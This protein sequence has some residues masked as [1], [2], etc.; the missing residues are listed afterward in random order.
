MTM[1][2]DAYLA[3]LMREADPHGQQSVEWLYDRVGFCTASRFKDACDVLK[4]GSESAK[5]RNY[6]LETVAARLIG[7][8][9]EH[10]VSDEMQWGTDQEPHARMAYEAATGAMVD[11]V[12]FLRHPTVEWCGGSPDGLI[13]KDGGIE[14][15]C[16][17]TQT[18][19]MTLLG[20]ECDYLHQ[21][22]GLL[23]ITGRQWFDFISFD[24]RMPSGLQLFV[25][26]IE[27]D[28]ELIAK[29]AGA[30]LTFLIEC[31]EMVAELRKREKPADIG[32]VPEWNAP[33]DMD[34][35]NA[36][37]DKLGNAI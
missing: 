20:A 16:P 8:P 34:R 2:T 9:I 5:R 14:I 28:D 21:I 23:W 15:K 32:T 31:A 26:R 37:I 6:K 33:V 7:R 36:A 18:H 24:P 4:N 22:Q 12:G 3:D 11:Q 27:R 13:G 1:L 29:L 25:R 17:T 19:I 10:F 35:L 30:I